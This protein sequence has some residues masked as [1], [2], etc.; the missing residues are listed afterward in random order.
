VSNFEVGDTIDFLNLSVNSFTFDGSTLTLVTS[1]GNLNYQFAGTEAG[2]AMNVV[3]DGHG[4]TSV[5][6]SLL[7]QFSA[8][9]MPAKARSTPQG[10]DP[11]SNS[12]VHAQS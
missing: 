6:L 1:G 7:S 2:T 12:L 11:Q 4:G 10:S 5:S 9:R 3:S 8:S